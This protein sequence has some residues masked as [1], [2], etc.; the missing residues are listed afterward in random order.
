MKINLSSLKLTVNENLTSKVTTFIVN[1]H[2]FK[3]HV[4][5]N[6]DL[7]SDNDEDILNLIVN[8]LR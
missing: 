6:N 1:G 5:S 8:I 4:S 2:A 3:Q 7:H